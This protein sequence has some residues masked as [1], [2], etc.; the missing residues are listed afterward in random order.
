MRLLL[1]LLA[2]PAFAADY[3]LQLTPDN[4]KIDWTLG[5]VL[6]TVHGTFRLKQG[7]ITFDPDTG[8]ASG[9]V[10]VDVQSGESG[11]GARDHRMHANVLESAKYPEAVFTPDRMEGKLSLDAPSAVKL[12]GT[13]RIHGAAHELTM[14]VQAKP[15]PGLIS[16]DITFHVPYV[17]WGMK[18]PSTFLLKVNKTVEMTIHTAAPLQKPAS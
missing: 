7:T 2:I 12:H 14:D 17:A 13:F 15:G 3:S 11:S 16:A 5:D 1:A 18:D 9:Q 8:K 4:T 6:H 10:V